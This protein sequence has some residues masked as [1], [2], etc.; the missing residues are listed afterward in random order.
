MKKLLVSVLAI[1]GLVACNNE[2]TLVK[3]NDK[4]AMEFGAFV[5][6]ALT[7]RAAQDPSL[8]TADLTSFD[9]WAYMDSYDGLVLSD[10]DVELVNGAWSYAN[11]QY[12]LPGH[13]YYFTAIAPMNGENWDYAQTDETISFTN[14]EGTEDLLFATATSSTKDES[15]TAY[16]TVKLTFKHLLS[17]TKFTFK[18]GYTTKNM[19]IVVSNIQM[20]APESANYEINSTEAHKWTNYADEVTLAYGDV[21]RIGAGAKAEST[22]ERLTIPATAAQDYKITYDITVYSGEVVAFEVSKE[23]ILSDVALEQGKAYNFVATITPDNII[24]GGLQPIVFEVV[25]V[26]D[27]VYAGQDEG[28]IAEA[29]LRAAVQLGGNVELTNNVVLTAPLNVTKDLVLNLNG[30][31]LTNA[32]ENAATDVIVVAEGATLT[33]EG[34]G[35]IEAVS[36]NDGYAIISE[37]TVVING[38]EIKAGVDANGAANAVVY[39]R[40]NGQVYV[41]GGY[42]PNDNASKYVLNKKDADRATTHIEVRGGKF[43]GFDPANNAAENPAENFVA[44]G[45]YSTEVAA[46]VFLVSDAYAVASIEQLQKAIDANIKDIRFA[47]DMV[48]D[49][50]IVQNVGTY[51]VID[52]AGYK[53]DGSMIVNGLS[54]TSTDKSLVI[55]N[56]NFET[57][58]TSAMNFIGYTSRYARNITIDNCTFT[59]PEGDVVAVKLYQGYN[60]VVKNCVMN[61]GHSLAQY[62]SMKNVVFESNTVNSLRGINLGNSVADGAVVKNCNI[63]ATKADGYAVRVDNGDAVIDGCDL[64]AFQPV[65]L[66]K[67]DGNE[68]ITF[69]NDTL[70]AGD[71]YQIFVEGNKPVLVGAVTYTCNK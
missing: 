9:V 50:N 1:A 24:D 71:E 11:L 39:A 59:A 30:F 45:Y 41:N 47:A 32:V 28:Q 16:E 35:V 61:G 13:D 44:E 70:T 3:H 22:Y 14:V 55:K 54:S 10:E 31:T 43:V 65:V 33:V 25:E 66:R 63:V 38:G 5:E 36:G 48:G 7:T 2:Q 23:T 42:F 68:V 34:E 19:D 60:V 64:T 51:Y 4:V 18:N 53:F 6:N 57:A 20:V 67:M 17:K 37:G 29:E 46:N 8:K 12:W 15:V 27:W 62:T 69:T 49:I 21:E 56:V 52:G 26:V 40:G 58:K